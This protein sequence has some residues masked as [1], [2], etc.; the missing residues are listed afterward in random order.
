MGFNTNTFIFIFLPVSILIS[1]LHSCKAKDTLL[2]FISFLFFAWQKP[3]S[4][5]VLLFIIFI[6]FPFGLILYKSKETRNRSFYLIAAIS[7][8]LLLLGTFKYFN[9]FTQIINQLLH[10]SIPQKDISVPLGISFFTFTSI[11]FLVDVYRGI[12]VDQPS[13]L[14]VALYISFFPKMA[15]GPITRFKTFYANRKNTSGDINSL[16]NGIERFIIGL[17]KKVLI[18]DTLGQVVDSIWSAGPSQNTVAIAWLGAICYTLQIYYDFSGYTDMAIGIGEILGFHLPENFNFPYISKS[19]TE[20]W[21]RWHITLGSFFKDYVYIP[22]GGNRCGALRTYLNLL[23]VFFLTGLWHGASWHYILW[24]L[25]NGVFMLIERWIHNQHFSFKFLPNSLK[26]LFL[27]VYALFITNIAWVFFR[28][29]N[30][31]NAVHYIKT[32]FGLDLGKYPGFQIQWYLNLQIIIV[33][34]I[35]IVLASGIQKKLVNKLHLN[36]SYQILK[37]TLLLGLF[38]ISLVKVVTGSYSSFIYFQF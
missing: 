34:I 36:T 38:F 26:N 15:Q 32:M 10:V 14:N 17:G 12:L 4:I 24:G 13:F 30:T 3:K 27:S 21:R 9:F 28:A 16:A 8:N 11:S 7:I 31:S 19:I 2:L 35:A 37:Y 5:L 20:F 18:A 1:F 23:T 25:F 6:N 33:L 29:P 22:L